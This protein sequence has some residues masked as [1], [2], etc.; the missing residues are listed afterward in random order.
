MSIILERLV[1]RLHSLLI[2]DRVVTPAQSSA[3]NALLPWDA[4]YLGGNW[5]DAA[6][7]MV[8]GSNAWTQ[9]HAAINAGLNDQWATSNSPYSLMYYKRDVIPTH[10]GIAEGFTVADMYAVSQGNYHSLG[11]KY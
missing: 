8:G 6:Q 1:S 7:C 10:F 2:Y 5:T 4:A 9:N 11:C 3:T